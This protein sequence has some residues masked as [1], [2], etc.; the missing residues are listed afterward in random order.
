M[1]GIVNIDS[2]LF[3]FSTKILN[4]FLLNIL[5]VIFSLPIITVGAATSS[6][7][8]VTLKMVRNE[9]GYIIQSFFQAFRQNFKQSIIIEF[10]LL[11][12]GVILFGDIRYFLTMDN[13]FG[14]ICAS[15]FAI[16]LTIYVFVLIFVFPLIAKY[17][18]TVIGTLK[19]AVVMSLRHLPT[20]IAVAIL[21]ISMLYGFYVSVP[22][23]IIISL[24]GVSGY[25]YIGSILFRNTF[26]KH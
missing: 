4:L 10:V 7:Y 16:G 23:M 19:N 15:I 3:R 20:S 21:L 25:A 8:Y 6:L 14:Y 26:E 13:I 5:W 17:N 11:I 9:E 12:S 22:L 1:N 18:N 24:I 2:R